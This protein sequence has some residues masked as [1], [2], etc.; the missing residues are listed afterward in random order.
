MTE[1][2]KEKAFIWYNGA[3]SKKERVKAKLDLLKVLIIAV[4]TALFGAVSFIG[5]NYDNIA[6][7]KLIFAFF[8]VIIL[9]CML[10]YFGFHFSKELD[11]LEKL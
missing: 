1:F 2:S 10:A 4:L 6:R 5:L 8:G 11:R 3:M 7:D 9:L